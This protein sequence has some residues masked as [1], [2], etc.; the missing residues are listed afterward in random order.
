MNPSEWQAVRYMLL[1][2]VSF[3]LMNATA[4]Y[5]DAF[6]TYEII[7][8]RALGSF[9][10]C[11]FLLSKNGINILGNQR[12][13]L[14]A[15]SLIGLIAMVF[16]FKAMKL[17]PLG[18]VV[19]L[20]YLAPIFAAIFAVI[21]LKDKLKPI[22]WFYFLMAFAGVAI[23]KGFDSSININGLVFVLISAILTGVVFVLIRRIGQGDHPL[24]IVN[25][26]MFTS[27]IAGLVFGCSTWIRPQGLEWVLLFSL[28]LTGFFGQLFMT[29]ALQTSSISKVAPVKY[30]EAVFALLMGLFIFGESYTYYSLL[31]ISLIIGGMLLNL[32]VK[33]KT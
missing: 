16:F 29:K 6:S 21:F 33:S 9:V 13:L 27:M 14:V 25:Y 26:F 2:T 19:S 1:S 32:R 28:G 5:L 10:L 30:S 20:R 7:F 12:G 11:V 31:G 18:T 15:R 24:V 23:L 22:Q 8:F 17:L 4:K 3:T